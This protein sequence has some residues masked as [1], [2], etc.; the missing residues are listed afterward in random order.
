MSRF[1][2][3]AVALVPATPGLALA[4]QAE[5]P[6]PQA[7]PSEQARIEADACAFLEASFAEVYDGLRRHSAPP[8][9]GQRS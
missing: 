8:P 2:V 6:R 4:Q 1:S 9:G 3:F 5:T 7:K